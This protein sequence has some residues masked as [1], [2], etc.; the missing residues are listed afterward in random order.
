MLVLKTGF[1]Q[2]PAL[3]FRLHELHSYQTPEFLVL[4]V[5]AGSDPFLEWLQASLRQA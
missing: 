3:E 4:N 2:L 1:A 5:E